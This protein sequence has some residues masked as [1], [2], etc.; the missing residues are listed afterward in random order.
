M[1]EEA[2]KW[3]DDAEEA[4]DRASEAMKAA[5]EGTKDVRMSALEAAREAATQLGKAIDQG[6]DVARDSWGSA[7]SQEGGAED[8]P[9]AELA[10]DGSGTD[11]EE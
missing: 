9:P 11:E 2:K 6:I 7:K 5:W 8:A 3:M 4:L 10:A 1:T